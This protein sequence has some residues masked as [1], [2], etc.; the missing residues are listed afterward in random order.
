MGGNGILWKPIA[1]I[2]N[3]MDFHGIPMETHGVE[4]E[5]HGFPWATI[6]SKS[7]PWV[8]IGV[9]LE[10]KQTMDFHGQIME[11]HC[12]Q[13]ECHAFSWGGH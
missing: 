13:L 11:I 4:L 6:E 9:L 3:T 10:L 2:F 1:L 8:S 5:S 7:E 12:V